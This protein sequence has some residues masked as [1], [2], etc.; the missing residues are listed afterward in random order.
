MATQ[1]PLLEVSSTPT[2]VPVEVW[3]LFVCEADRVRNSGRTHY[4]AR[5]I[6]EFIR[7]HQVINAGNRDFVVNNNWQAGIA[8]AYMALRNCP[9]FFETREKHYMNSEAA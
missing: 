4:S 6:L 5:T 7:H 3:R 8:R 2:G 1:L 9:R